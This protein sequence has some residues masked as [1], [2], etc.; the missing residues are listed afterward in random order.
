ML[1][2][3]WP[4]GVEM[5]TARHLLAAVPFHLVVV[6]LST[7]C[8]WGLGAERMR[9]GIPNSRRGGGRRRWLGSCG[10]ETKAPASRGN[11]WRE[12]SRELGGV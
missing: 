6:F 1:A 4:R 3:A 11:G 5:L 8:R 2:G 9:H 7:S 10:R 12:G